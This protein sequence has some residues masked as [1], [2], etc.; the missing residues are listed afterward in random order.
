MR[1]QALARAML[2][3]GAATKNEIMANDRKEL[4][5]LVHS[6]WEIS[7]LDKTRPARTRLVQASGS[8]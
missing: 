7:D 4:G 3:A 6:T 8:I 1:H 5:Q 2:R